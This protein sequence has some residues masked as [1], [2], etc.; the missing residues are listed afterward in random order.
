LALVSL[1]FLLG[2]SLPLIL[3]LFGLVT[4]L[5]ADDLGYLRV[6]KTRV[7]RYYLSLVMLTI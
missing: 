5:L 6:G 4:P 3:A 2:Q 1:F 7:L